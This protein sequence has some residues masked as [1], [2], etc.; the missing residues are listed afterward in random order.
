MSLNTGSSKHLLI[1]NNNKLIE[2]DTASN[3]KEYLD[4][5]NHEF[6][7]CEV[8]YPRSFDNLNVGISAGCAMAVR[9]ENK[10]LKLSA[11]GGVD[12]ILEDHP[13]ADLYFQNQ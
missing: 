4:N 13:N 7:H 5:N 6:T 1:N 10:Q 9:V 12:W 2:F 3:A 11:V 8:F